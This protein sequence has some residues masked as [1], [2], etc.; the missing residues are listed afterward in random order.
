[1]ILV[2][3]MV[4]VYS[5]GSKH[6]Q[7][8]RRMAELLRRDEVLGHEFVHG[9]LLLGQGGDARKKIV[10]KYRDLQQAPTTPHAA[11]LA[12][13]EEHSLANRGIGWVD[14]HLLAAARAIG[15]TLW[16]EEGPL[17]KAAAMVGIAYQPRGR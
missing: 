2:D 11:M 8:S 16:T 5:A 15:S 14:A 12:F 10:E 1:M 13:V 3:T 7:I 4:W 6:P 9:E 17:R